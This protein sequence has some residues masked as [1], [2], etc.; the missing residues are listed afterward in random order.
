[1]ECK[2]CGRERPVRKAFKTDWQ[3][4]VCDECLDD[5]GYGRRVLNGVFEDVKTDLVSKLDG[6]IE[7][8]V[9]SELPRFIEKL[10]VESG[11][12]FEL[13]VR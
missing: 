2:I 5:M 4:R 6:K 9:Q 13:V 1:M 8:A 3:R 11:I 7:R 12:E 10:M